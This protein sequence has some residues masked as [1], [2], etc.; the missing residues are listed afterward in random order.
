MSSLMV[1]LLMLW[2]DTSGDDGDDVSVAVR[3]F[4]NKAGEPETIPKRMSRILDTHS[5]STGNFF[6]SNN[7]MRTRGVGIAVVAVVEFVLAVGPETPE[8]AL[9]C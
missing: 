5:S 9:A 4:C 7:L 6:F 8:A 2:D 3:R 1:L